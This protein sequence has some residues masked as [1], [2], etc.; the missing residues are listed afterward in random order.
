VGAHAVQ[1]VTVVR[2]DDHGA[3][4]LFRMFSSRIVLMSRWLVGSSSSSTPQVENRGSAMAKFPV[5]RYF[6]YHRNAAPAQYP[7]PA[8][9]L[10][11]TAVGKPSISATHLR[12]SCR[13]SCHLFCSFLPANKCDRA[14]RFF[15]FHS[16]FVTH[17]HGVDHAEFF[18]VSELDPDA[19]YPGAR[20][21]P[22]SPGH[23]S[24]PAG[25]RRESS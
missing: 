7:G 6:V 16:S 21:V 14:F 1:K 23:R 3:V 25:R 12:V 11:R 15:T 20:S 5:W 18:L 22:A 19:L 17:D 24:V 13:P 8:T 2:D 10:R 9:T 4:A